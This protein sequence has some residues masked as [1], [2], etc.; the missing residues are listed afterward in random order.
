[1]TNC[2]WIFFY[3]KKNIKNK[4]FDTRFDQKSWRSYRFIQF[5]RGRFPI[6]FDDRIGLWP[7]ISRLLVDLQLRTKIGMDDFVGSDVEGDLISRVCELVN[8]ARDI[9][10]LALFVAG[11]C[12]FQPQFGA[13]Q[14]LGFSPGDSGI[15]GRASQLE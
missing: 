12:L 11:C 4:L 14:Q 3:I 9:S 5:D 13:E 15:C 1:M 6:D 2:P 7:T 10:S 8:D